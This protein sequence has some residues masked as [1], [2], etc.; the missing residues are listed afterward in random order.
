MLTYRPLAILMF[1]DLWSPS[2]SAVFGVQLD[3]A[4][5]QDGGKGAAEA[6]GPSAELFHHGPVGLGTSAGAGPLFP[7]CLKEG[8]VPC[9]KTGPLSSFWSTLAR[10]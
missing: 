10:E 1:T 5:S 3:V 6:M 8:A 9:R 2:T 4:S 7:S